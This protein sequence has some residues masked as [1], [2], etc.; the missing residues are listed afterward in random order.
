VK[1][2]VWPLVGLS[3]IGLVASS[4]INFLARYGTITNVGPWEWILGVGC[5]VVAIPG[6]QWSGLQ[7]K[8]KELKAYGRLVV[9]VIGSSPAWLRYPIIAAWLYGAFSAWTSMDLSFGTSLET[10]ST[11]ELVGMSGVLMMVY[12]MS[13]AM[14]YSSA[15]KRLRE[16][17]AD[18]QRRNVID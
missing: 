16:D 11:R 2:W 14:L 1:R 17:L 3:A 15:V 12:S 18:T 8:S 7:D 10:D 4:A 6:F 5:F 9:A 13:L